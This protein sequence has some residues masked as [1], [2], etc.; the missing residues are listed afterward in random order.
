MARDQISKETIENAKQWLFSVPPKEPDTF[1]LP[2]AISMLSEAI[3]VA[4]TNG[5][6]P[7]E[8]ARMLKEKGFNSSLKSIK[9]ALPLKRPKSTKSKASPPKTERAEETTSA[10]QQ[11]GTLMS[12]PLH[13]G[14]DPT[15]KVI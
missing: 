10:A 5:Y 15:K 8:I 14:I 2:T 7:L 9:D 3:E 1:D 4:Q 6:T 11:T 12:N 13:Q